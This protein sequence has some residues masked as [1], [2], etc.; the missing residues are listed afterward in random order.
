[1]RVVMVP[2][3]QAKVRGHLLRFQRR[4]AGDVLQDVVA[5]IVADGLIDTGDMLG[6][7]RQEGTRVYVGTDHWHFLEYGT[8]PHS[9]YPNV[10]RALWWEDL[11][12]PVGHVNHP[13]NREYAFMRRAI[14]KKRG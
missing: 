11:A 9:I 4:I 12:H 14:H 3:W 13:G 7:V 5:N 10:K 6:S 1:M 2:G 8:R